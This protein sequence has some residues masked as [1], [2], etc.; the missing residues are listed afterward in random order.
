[1]LA[2][3]GQ[4]MTPT[5]EDH[6]PELPPA[7]QILTETEDDEQNAVIRF[8]V[9]AVCDARNRHVVY[10]LILLETQ[11]PVQ[12]KVPEDLL[13]GLERF[14]TALQTTKL[15][16]QPTIEAF[17]NLRVHVNK[18]LEQQSSLPKLPSQGPHYTTSTTA[19]KK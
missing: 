10:L 19:T 14:E 6:E 17:N 16:N 1:M 18:F 8:L 9:R 12:L 3:W 11:D 15:S 7:P 13:S 4:M 2:D 5:Y